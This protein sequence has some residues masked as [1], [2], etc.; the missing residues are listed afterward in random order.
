[1]LNAT[2]DRHEAKIIACAGELGR[3]TTATNMA[4]RGTDIKLGT[5]VAELGGLHIIMSERHDA[6]RIDRQLAGRC[7]RHGEPGSVEAILSLEDPLLETAGSG[8]ARRLATSLALRPGG[9]SGQATFDRAQRQTER[10]HSRMR[11]DL[12]RMDQKL[13]TMLA[14]SGR[15]E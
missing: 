3:I 8:R 15:V 7:G 14:F 5:G 6:G 4:G 2:Q 12:L 9:R 13:S 11:R 10:A 1:M